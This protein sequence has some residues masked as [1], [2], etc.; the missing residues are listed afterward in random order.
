M[1]LT[2]CQSLTRNKANQLSQ[3]KRN[4]PTGKIMNLN[5]LIRLMALSVG[6]V[7][8]LS[9]LPIASAQ[10]NNA[11]PLLPS[12]EVHIWQRAIY[13]TESS[14]VVGGIVGGI[15]QDGY[16]KKYPSDTI[17]GLMKDVLDIDALPLTLKNIQWQTFTK[18]PV[19]NIVYEKGVLSEYDFKSLKASKKKFSDSSNDCYIEIYIGKQ[20]FSGG[21]LKSHLFSDLYSRTF[22]GARFAAKGAIL[23]DQTSKVS[24]KDEASK[25]EARKIFGGSFVKILTKFL[26][27]KMPK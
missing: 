6:T 24:V 11:Q 1:I 10:E 15:I 16:D 21:T 14:S 8:M 22:Y 5:N 27:K 12:C 2:V 23:W 19:N 7:T 25:Q 26:E 13:A 20:T 17:Q 9:M 3:L 18:R 4:Q